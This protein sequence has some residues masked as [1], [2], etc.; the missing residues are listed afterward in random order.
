M[1]V[2]ASRRLGFRLAGSPMPRTATLV[3]VIKLNNLT[4]ER[5]RQCESSPKS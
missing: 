5:T 3:A 1:T 4:R 2:R